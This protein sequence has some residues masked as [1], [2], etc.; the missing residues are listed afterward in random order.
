MSHDI[1]IAR[2]RAV[3]NALEELKDE[4]VFVGGATVSLYASRAAVETRPT[5]D[6]DIAV[7][8]ISY[9][10]YVELEERLRNKGFRNDPAG[11]M[12]RFLLKGLTVDVIPTRERVLGFYNKWYGE[13][14]KNAQDYTIGTGVVVKI[15]TAPYFVASKFEALKQREPREELRESRDL[16]DIVFIL[17]NRRTIWEEMLGAEISLKHYLLKEFKNLYENRYIEEIIEGHAGIKSPSSAFFILEDM[18]SFVHR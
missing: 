1:N 5:E 15:F 6:V 14:F 3:S 8:L 9:M 7:E 10:K 12:G 11:H 18:E 2:I 4:V 13:G 17:E 16:E